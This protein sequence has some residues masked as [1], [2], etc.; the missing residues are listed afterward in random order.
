MKS[1]LILLFICMIS[2]SS[3]CENKYQRYSKIKCDKEVSDFL[4]AKTVK[5]INSADSVKVYVLNP[6]SKDTLGERYLEYKTTRQSDTLSNVQLLALHSILKSKNSYSFD[7]LVKNCTLLPNYSV[8]FFAKNKNQQLDTLSILLDFNCDT[9]YFKY[10][11]QIKF[12]DFDTVRDTLL[13]WLR[14]VFTKN[15]KVSNSYDMEKINSLIKN[16]F[17]EKTAKQIKNINTVSAFLLNPE[18]ESED[19]TRLFNGFFV[20]DK[21]PKLQDVEQ[22]LIMDILQNKKIITDSR[23]AKNCTFLP[24]IGFRIYAKDKSYTDI[25]VAFYCNDWLLI[26][27]EKRVITDCQSI[28]KELLELATK[29]FPEDEYLRSISP[30]K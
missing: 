14:S 8:S 15:N 11:N 24:D 19:T 23:L 5:F 4:G 2:L 16:Q 25:L 20:V 17:G 7:S 6:M 21:V 18:K 3:T 26:N 30:E 22:K 29:T 1:Q 12:E 9:W 13:V 10:D 27:N 28:R